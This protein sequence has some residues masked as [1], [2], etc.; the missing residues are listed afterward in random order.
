MS[1]HLE[2]FQQLGFSLCAA[3]FDL[4]SQQLQ[5]LRHVV[6]AEG[7]HIPRLVIIVY[8]FEE[9]DLLE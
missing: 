8:L 3:G 7:L 9:L 5:F 1:E 4:V 6:L 2:L